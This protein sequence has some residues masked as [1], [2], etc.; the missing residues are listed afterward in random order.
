M[1]AGIVVVGLARH[2]KDTVC[3]ILRDSYGLSF[4]SSSRVLLEEVIYPVLKDKYAYASK[5]ECYEDRY[6]HRKE[7]FDLLAA[8]NA[9]DKAKLGKLIF[10]K[11][12]VYC[13]LRNRHELDALV[14]AGLVN[15][16]IWVDAE[17]RLGITE[18][19]DSI[20]ITEDDANHILDNNQSLAD[21]RFEIDLLMG[22]LG[23]EPN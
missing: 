17:D 10:S 3:E 1:S 4:E 19:C 9:E 14:A 12:D 16:I 18:F 2:G 11:Y 23:Y 8:Y 15:H 5:E 13:G 22:E 6:S 7:W 21:L 20:T